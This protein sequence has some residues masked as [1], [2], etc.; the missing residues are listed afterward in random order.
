M[1]ISNIDPF[2]YV[3]IAGVCNAIYRSEFLPENTVG[4]VNE[5]ASD[6]YSF[7][8]IK[9]MKYLMAN[10]N[11]KIR[12][13]CNGGE[14]TIT[15]NQNRYKVDG[16]CH[17]NNTVYQ[18]HGCYYHGCPTCYN[19][20]TIN[21]AN[22]RYMKDLYK[23]TKYIDN[24]IREAGYNLFTIWE[25]EFDT[26][27]EART[28]TL[29]DYDLVEPP[30]IRDSFYG[31]RCEPVKLMK[32]FTLTADTKGKYID[33]VSL[34]PTVMYYDRYPVGHPKKIIKPADY[35]PEWFGFAYVKILPPRKLYLP[36]LPYKQKANQSH[37]LL[38]GLCRTCME[39]IDIKC[40]HHKGSK[41]KPD[42]KN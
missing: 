3:T 7:K 30:K 32:D 27:K 41:C 29:D 26:N 34:Y 2:Q 38:F 18:F 20:L 36:V 35:D 14:I 39:R 21:D 4:I 8:S 24:A 16:Y 9:W 5:T 11:I 13:A 25:H 28:T 15:T 31:G 6:T 17:E 37:K 40:Y 42:C 10:E 23:N 22:G 12:N 33:V 19:E 1:R